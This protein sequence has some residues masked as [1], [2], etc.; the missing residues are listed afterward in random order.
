[1]SFSEHRSRAGRRLEK[2]NPTMMRLL[3]SGF[4]LS[5]LTVGGAMGQTPPAA[6]DAVPPAVQSPSTNDGPPKPSGTI[7]EVVKRGDVIQP[8]IP[9]APGSTIKPPNVDPQ[10]VIPPPGTPGGD[11]T[12]NPK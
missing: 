8:Q 1:M 9:G 3:I 10:L 12:V 5:A 11:R 6:T 7:P 2:E 4:C